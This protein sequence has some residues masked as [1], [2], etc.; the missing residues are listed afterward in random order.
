[1]ERYMKCLALAAAGAALVG[2]AACSQNAAPAAAPAA[3]RAVHVPVSCRQQYHTWQN[4]PGKGLIA[5]L[6][7]VGVAGAAG[8]THTLTVAL[9]N[10]RPAVAE[11]TRHPVPAC[12]D[13]RGI[14]TVLLMHVSAAVVSR[15]SPPSARAAMKGVLKVER[16]LAA[17]VRQMIR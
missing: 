12:A 2:L 14:W 4:G 13:P 6:H 1:M 8:D 10:A 3:H 7:A 16:K 9:R 11:A 15:H 5:T 17:E